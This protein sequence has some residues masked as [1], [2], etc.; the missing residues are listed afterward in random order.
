MRT[1]IDRILVIAIGALAVALIAAQ[2]SPAG[3]HGGGTDKYGGH[4]EKATG[5]YHCHGKEGTAKR[6]RCE[7]RVRLVEAEKLA[8]SLARK[9][10]TLETGLKASRDEARDLSR[11]LDIARG[12]TRSARA[13]RDTQRRSALAA[14]LERDNAVRD[15]REAEARAAGSGPAVSSRCKDG[16]RAAL[17]SGWRF[18]RAEKEALRRACLY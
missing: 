15:M 18:S 5:L 11:Q 4:V 8:V 12:E 13:A 9:N 17:D 6:E 14:A 7:M 1:L 2:L 16:V 10:A 3:A